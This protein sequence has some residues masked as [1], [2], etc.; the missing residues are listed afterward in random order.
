MWLYHICLGLG[1]R[2]QSRRSRGG[3]PAS[4]ARSRITSV[5]DLAQP[6]AQLKR[7][8][9]RLRI[10]CLRIGELLAQ[11]LRTSVLLPSRLGHNASVLLFQLKYTLLR[12]RKFVL[13]IARASHDTGLLGCATVSRIT[14]LDGA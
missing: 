13:A 6:I 9:L 3:A 7:L 5:L 8:F 12:C 1:A 11:F 14:L 10:P 4:A 2:S